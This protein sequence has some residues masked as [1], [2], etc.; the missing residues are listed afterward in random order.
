MTEIELTEN[1]L[2]IHVQGVHKILAF[3]LESLLLLRCLI[4]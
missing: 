2:L 3:L 1:T 4:V